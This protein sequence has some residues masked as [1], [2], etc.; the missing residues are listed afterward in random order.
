MSNLQG[1]KQKD[2]ITND[3]EVDDEEMNLQ[4]KRRSRFIKYSEPM[5]SKERNKKQQKEMRRKFIG[6]VLREVKN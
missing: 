3:D 2:G 1:E 5:S 6:K 4:K